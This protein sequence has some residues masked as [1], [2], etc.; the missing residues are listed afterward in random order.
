MTLEDIFLNHRYRGII[1]C[2]SRNHGV[3]Q[4]INDADAGLNIEEKM[5]ITHW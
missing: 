2:I 1:A 4:F 3:T 5:G